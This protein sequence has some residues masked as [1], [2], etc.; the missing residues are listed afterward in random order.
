[1]RKGEEYGEKRE[2]SGKKEER[3]EIENS[4]GI[5]REGGKDEFGKRE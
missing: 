3:G 1:M 5:K 2:G 4:V